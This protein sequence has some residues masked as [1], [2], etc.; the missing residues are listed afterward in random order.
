MHS[1]HVHQIVCLDSAN[2]RLV[3]TARA[4]HIHNAH[5]YMHTE[6]ERARVR[7]SE[8]QRGSLV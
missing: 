3:F 2:A 6:R 5:T 1:D 8:K 4:S 7:E